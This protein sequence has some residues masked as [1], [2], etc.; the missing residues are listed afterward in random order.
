MHF[1]RGRVQRE[2]LDP[3]AHNLLQLQLFKYPVESA[4]LGP[5]V[6][7]RVD[8]MPVTE[9]SR[10]PTPLAPVIGHIQQ[11]IQKLQVRQTYITRCTGRLSL[12]LAYCSSVISIYFH[13]TEARWH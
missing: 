11:R 12:I 4:T 6:H 8:G 3:D 2:S 13:F 5:A 9:P 10:Q 1:H 7:A